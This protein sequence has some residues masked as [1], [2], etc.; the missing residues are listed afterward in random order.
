MR[1]LVPLDGSP[2]AEYALG[3]A[4]Q[5]ARRATKPASVTLF[6]VETPV[7]MPGLTGEVLVDDLR[8]TQSYLNDV[9]MLPTLHGLAVDTHVVMGGGIADAICKYARSIQA[10]LIIMTSHGR[11]GLARAALGSI[12]ESVARQSSI[13]TLITRLDMSL[14]AEE[15]TT[16]PFTILVPLDGSLPSES[17]LP[18]AINMAHLLHAVIRLI[19]VLPSQSGNVERDR[20]TMRIAEAYLDGIKLRLQAESLTVECTYAWG[21][22]TMEIV[23]KAQKPCDMIAI[24]THGRAGIEQWV[25]GSVTAALIHQT[26]HPILVIHPHRERKR[27]PIN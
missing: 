25:A 2:L 3:L 9:A 7:T 18:A 4:A 10:D 17:S 21:D 5:L 14:C 15:P 19:H 1:I 24:A 6:T 20:N 23:K 8:V 26:H 22:P 13:P 11:T 12:T 16:R 27:L